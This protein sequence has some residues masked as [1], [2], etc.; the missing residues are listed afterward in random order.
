VFQVKKKEEPK[1]NKKMKMKPAAVHSTSLK[2]ETTYFDAYAPENIEKLKRN[3]MLPNQKKGEDNEPKI[4]NGDN[5]ENTDSWS[6]NKDNS[7]GEEVTGTC[8]TS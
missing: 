7:E 8:L 5:S 6:A 3:S 1:K 2:E 4:L